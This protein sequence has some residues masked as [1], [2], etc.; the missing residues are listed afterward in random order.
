MTCINMPQAYTASR[1][2]DEPAPAEQGAASAA[3]PDQ[4]TPPSLPADAGPPREASSYMP[5]D[6]AGVP[7]GC[8]HCFAC[9]PLSMHGHTHSLHAC[10]PG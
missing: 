9:M 8:A 10:L 5:P 3:A 1:G 7:T 6:W 2:A 4:A